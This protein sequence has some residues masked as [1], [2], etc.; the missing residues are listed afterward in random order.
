MDGKNTHGNLGGLLMVQWGIRFLINKDYFIHE[1][2]IYIV[3]TGKE[4]TTQKSVSDRR[5]EFR[6]WFPRG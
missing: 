5:D 2:L 6:F 1:G 3:S 4:L